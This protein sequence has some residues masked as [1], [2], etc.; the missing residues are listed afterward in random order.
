[1]GEVPATADELK[2]ILQPVEG[3]WDMQAAGKPPPPPKPAP[4]QASLF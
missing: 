3:D 2:T 4:A 1:L